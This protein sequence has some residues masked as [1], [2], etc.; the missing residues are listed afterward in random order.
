MPLNSGDMDHNPIRHIDLECKNQGT[1]IA[2]AKSAPLAYL[3]ES[4]LL[5]MRLIKSVIEQQS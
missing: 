1:G 2:R 4:G 5:S 3:Q